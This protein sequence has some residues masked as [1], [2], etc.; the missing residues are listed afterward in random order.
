MISTIRYLLICAGIL[1]IGYNIYQYIDH[2]LSSRK[3]LQEAVLL[4]DTAAVQEGTESGSGIVPTAAGQA[5]AAVGSE[6]EDPYEGRAKFQPEDD[7]VIGILEIP[8]INAK[9]PVIEGTEEQMLKRGV[10]HYTSSAFPLD[11]E[12][13]LLS[14]HRDTVFRKFGQLSI[15]D[16]FIVEL[17]YG[18]FE[19][20]MRKSEIVESDDTTVIRSMGEEVLTISTC[21][22]FRYVGDAPQRYIIYAYPVA[23]EGNS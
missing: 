20:E 1:I 11:G 17:P 23:P 3:A 5:L 21:Y 18:R 2:Q 12:Q 4:L 22:P 13:I 8:K 10:G 6:V 9:L 19:Y 15:G 14:G 16:R 7:E